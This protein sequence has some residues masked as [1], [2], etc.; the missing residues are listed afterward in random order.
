MR[1]FPDVF[2]DPEDLCDGVVLNTMVGPPMEI[3]LR[4]DAKPF[5]H[6][7]PNAIPLAWQEDTNGQNGEPKLH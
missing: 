2:V 4:P 6:H 7:T 1:E 5:A 3:Y